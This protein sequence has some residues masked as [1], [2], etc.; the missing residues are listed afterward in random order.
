MGLAED[1]GRAAEERGVNFPFNRDFIDDIGKIDSVNAAS[2]ILREGKTDDSVFFWAAILRLPGL[3]NPATFLLSASRGYWTR[4]PFILT[5]TEYIRCFYVDSLDSRRKCPNDSP[6]LFDDEHEIRYWRE[7]ENQTK[8]GFISTYHCGEIPC[9]DM[10]R[11]FMEA[12]DRGKCVQIGYLLFKRWGEWHA[13]MNLRTGEV[14]VPGRKLK[15]FLQQCAGDFN[16]VLAEDEV[17][18]AV[19]EEEMR[20]HFAR[21]VYPTRWSDSGDFLAFR[22]SFLDRCDKIT[23]QCE[24]LINSTAKDATTPK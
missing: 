22:Q 23:E 4:F 24:P 13:I 12:W 18:A 10:E 21:F 20:L 3:L 14:Y 7:W 6:H 2:E 17:K 5:L 9:P 19:G 1:I 16:P 11:N 15:N 8:P